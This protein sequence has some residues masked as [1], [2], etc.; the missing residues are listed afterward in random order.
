MTFAEKFDEVGNLTTRAEVAQQLGQPL[1]KRSDNFPDGPFMGP[2]EGLIGVVEYG[3]AFEEWEYQDSGEV[4]LIFF[5][6]KDT[7]EPSNQWNV[8]GKI[9]YPQGAAF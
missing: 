5:A 3:Q 1:K 7:E 2:Q 8:V 6:G 4:F 9:R